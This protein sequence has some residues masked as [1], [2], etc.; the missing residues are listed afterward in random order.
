MLLKQNL[1]FKIFHVYTR[2]NKSEILSLLSLLIARSFK[3]SMRKIQYFSPNVLVRR[4]F[5]SGQ[6]L[7]VF[8]RIASKSTETVGLWKMWRKMLYFT[9]FS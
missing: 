2:T 8:E 1:V 5:L 9:Q 3:T 7:H 6:F 4:F